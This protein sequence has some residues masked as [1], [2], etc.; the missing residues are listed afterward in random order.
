[1]PRIGLD[2]ALARGDQASGPERSGDSLSLYFPGA[3][4][5]LGWEDRMHPHALA[6][7]TEWSAGPLAGVA[8]ELEWGV[9]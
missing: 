3:W 8:R 1:L 7:V 4:E 2:P 9:H 5:G 6:A